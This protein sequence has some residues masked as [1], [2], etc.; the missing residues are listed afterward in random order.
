[1]TRQ[2]RGPGAFLSRA[3]L[4]LLC[5]GLLLGVTSGFAEAKERPKI[6]LALSGGGARGAAHVGVLKVLEELRI[7]I[8]YIAGTSMGAIVGGLYA[9]GMTA[10]QLEQ[11]LAGM[12]WDAILKDEEPRPERRFRR[13]Q[14]DR[15][16]LM[17]QKLGV[18][19]GEVNLGPALI[20]GQKLDLELE[21]LTL[22]VSNVR[23]FDRLPI[24]FRA[25]ATDIETGNEV[26]LRSG[27]LPRA[28]RASMAVPAVF[29]PVEIDGRLLVDGFVS[30]NLPVSAV[31]AMGAEIIIA[32]DIGT[33]PLRKQ[34]ITNALAVVEQLTNLMSVRGTQ[35]EIKNLRKG[36][37]LVVPQ[38]GDIGGGDFKRVLEA[39]RLG[40]QAADAQRSELAR[41]GVPPAAYQA[42]QARHRPP[43]RGTQQVGFVRIQND[44]ELQDAVLQ[45]HLG[46]KPGEPLDID[47]LERGIGQIYDLDNFE[48]VR[49][50]IVEEN[51]ETGVVVEAKRKRWGTSSIQAG[52]QLSTNF[53]GNSSFNLGAAFT[54]MPVNS[55]NG[56]WRTLLRLGEEPSLYTDLYQPLDPAERWFIQPGAGYV[57]TNYKIFADPS[58]KRPT[59]EYNAHRWGITLEGGRNLDDW[60]R[61]SLGY[62]RYRG[63]LDIL[64]GDPGIQGY[65]FD[66]GVL[67][68]NFQ[69]DTLDSLHFPREGWFGG[70]RGWT[71]RGWLGAS[72]DFDQAMAG[73][74]R[75]QS[76][77]PHTLSG[78]AVFQ[79]TFGGDAELQNL[80]RLGGFQHLSGMQQDQLA[81]PNATLLRLGYQYRLA[82]GLVPAYLGGSLELGNVWQRRSDINLRD[83]I[84]AASLYLGA[85]TFLGPLYVAFGFAEGGNQAF[86]LFLGQP[87]QF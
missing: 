82:G 5:A 35:R 85:D 57:T 42:F 11:A 65:K 29:A 74:Y 84:P 36:D 68:L 12:D 52:L 73:L 53:N 59:L 22:P 55:L 70:V 26:V 27:Q 63:N 56:E 43:A 6:G 7:P 72:N 76:W 37:V 25:I 45:S 19:G 50:D 75:A 21:A 62:Q 44:S 79:T 48:S 47:R 61:V 86:Y 51:G 30:S 81:G 41:L 31:R 24:P 20:L 38:L 3:L 18:E 15:L 2:C 80:F 67:A 28:I 4:L 34:D 66:T 10:T 49:Y 54:L 16:L 64:V 33:P 87:W 77:G 71:S 17:K 39:S 8:D 60:G 14:D 46:V 83:S 32:V 58:D 1:M 13:K 9:S 69:V 40:Y 78:G 23:D